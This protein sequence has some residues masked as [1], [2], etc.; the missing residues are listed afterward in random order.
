MGAGRHGKENFYLRN[1]F[2][3]YLQSK[4]LSKS[5]IEYYTCN[6]SL[7]MAWVNKEEILITKPDIL[8]YLVY[9]KEV[10]Q[11]ENKGRNS[12][13]RS[14]NHYFTFLLNSG[15][16][17][18]NPTDLLKMRGT[19]KKTLHPKLYTPEELEQILDNYYHGFI[20]NFN[21]QK[22]LE[23]LSHQRNY[24]ILGL[25]IYQGVSREEI[26]KIHLQDLNLHKGSIKIRSGKKSNERTIP[27]KASQIGSLINYI[28]NIRPRFFDY[29]TETEK[30][31]FAFHENFRK[32]MNRESIRLIY[33]PFRTQIKSID[34]HFLNFKHIRTSVITT[35]LKTEGLRKTQYLA[36]NRYI[37]ST[38]KY[39]P[40]QI[41]GLIED[42]A[43][44][45][46]F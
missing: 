40:N 22:E 20:R 16:V 45:N 14:L 39:L 10:K 38:E 26:E 2:I 8:K 4:D 12:R 18:S 11:M 23:L 35:W 31:F 33:P 44:F 9:L 17:A 24:I 21:D 15:D 34:K 28:D 3:A 42:V 5:T 1:D 41:E 29:C 43:K 25:L 7:F 30:L 6:L 37:S 46:P 13:L 27:L 32:K 19:Q 36:G